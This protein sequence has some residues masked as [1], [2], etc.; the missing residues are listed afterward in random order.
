MD[1]PFDQS[2][3]FCTHDLMIDRRRVFGYNT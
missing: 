3:F 2:I 1:R